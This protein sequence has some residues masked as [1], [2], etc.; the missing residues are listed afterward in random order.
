MDAKAIGEG[1]AVRIREVLTKGEM[2]GLL[3]LIDRTIHISSE[4]GL[5]ALDP[6]LKRLFPFDFAMCGMSGGALAEA[7]R[8]EC[9]INLSYPEGFISKY[10]GEA[11]FLIDPV[12]ALE[13]E[14]PRLYY[15]KDI[16][17]R[18]KELDT[19]ESREF[20][21]GFGIKAGYSTGVKSGQLGLVSVFSFMAPILPRNERSELIIQ[22]VA[23]HLHAA[24]RRI[25]RKFRGP[26]CGNPLT[27]REMEVLDWV[28][29]GRS[30]WQI[31]LTLG[32]S[33][34]TVK[35]HIKN[36][37]HKLDATTR[38]QALAEAI[39]RGYVSLD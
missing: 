7:P 30:T 18:R 16:L 38:G 4:E 21:G 24:L 29:A 10:I 13:R 31:S 34:A 9:C 6:S 35:F 39:Q 23:P 11:R 36:I 17:D 32:L 12:V 14:E 15:L 33:E 5:K 19:E 8:V 37:M 26:S 2:V 22:L 28:K 25:F 3:E 20:A 1:I 27:A